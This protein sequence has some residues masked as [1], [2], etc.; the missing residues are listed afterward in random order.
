MIIL[1]HCAFV[2]H[3]SFRRIEEALRRF[4][5]RTHQQVKKIASQQ[6]YKR[7]VDSIQAHRTVAIMDSMEEFLASDFFRLSNKAENV[8]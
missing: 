3:S 1:V 2:M 7:V 8:R 5:E 6:E 4:I